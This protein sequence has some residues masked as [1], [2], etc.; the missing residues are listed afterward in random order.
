MN[1]S[2]LNSARRHAVLRDYGLDHHLSE[3]KLVERLIDTELRLKRLEALIF[4]NNLP[5]NGQDHLK[6]R[7]VA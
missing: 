1:L 6:H 4:G 5:I 3:E 7:E 2:M